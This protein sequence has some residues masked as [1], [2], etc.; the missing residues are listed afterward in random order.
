MSKTLHDYELKYSEIEKQA[1]SLVKVVAHFRTYILSSHVIAYVPTSPV[2]MLLNQQ[3]REGK[4]ENWLAKIQ[5]YD[6]EI[7]PLKEVRGQGLCKLMTGID[8]VN[9]DISISVGSSSSTSEWYK[10]I[11]FYLKS[12]QFPIGMSS[13]ERRALKMKE[14]QYVLVV[15]VLFQRNFDGMLL[16]CIDSTKSQKVLEEF[17]EGVCGGHFS[18]TTTAHRIMRVGYYWPTIFKDSYSMIRKCISCQKFS[19][20]MKR[21]TMLLQPIT[22]EEPFT[23]WGLDVI[24]P[25]NPN[26]QQGPFIHSHC[27]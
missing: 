2:K 19:G 8:A 1:L 27:N 7:K 6:I 26:L 12:G 4:W 11:I 21:A 24:G 14:N 18:P 9:G 22:I 13:K 17:H 10:D 23:Q 25:I 3:L 20:K 15:E 16:R 5:E